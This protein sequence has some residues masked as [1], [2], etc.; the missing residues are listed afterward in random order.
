MEDVLWALVTSDNITG[1]M[2]AGE[3]GRADIE[4]TA[5][6]AERGT[7][8]QQRLSR[9]EIVRKLVAGIA[10][11]A[12]M[13]L[14]ASSHPIYRHLTEGVMLD[15]AEDLREASDWQ[16]LFL[17]AAQDKT[18]AALSEAVV[19]GSIKAR[20]DRFIDLLL[21]VDTAE[22][23]REFGASLA[24]VEPEAQKR[25]GRDFAALTPS[26]QQTLLT[27]FS[28]QETSR[29][30]L[31]NLKEWIV[32]AYYSSEQGMRELGWNGNYAFESFPGCEHGDEHHQVTSD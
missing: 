18:L 17:N 25:F 11:G 10:A 22:H 5:H 20:V 30:H 13:P 29:E 2:A 23:Q 32:G 15:R 7:Q 12:A 28:K 1:E 19:P 31:Q 4:V 9:R 6:V 24:A 16:P 8:E 21:S 14:V 26:E 3:T 27:D